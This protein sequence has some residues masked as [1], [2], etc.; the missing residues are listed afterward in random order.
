MKTFG[1]PDLFE[2]SAHSIYQYFAKQSTNGQDV[3]LSTCLVSQDVVKMRSLETALEEHLSSGFYCAVQN[4]KASQSL[5]FSKS[6]DK[7]V[8]HLSTRYNC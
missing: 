3:Y 4:V 7:Y 2:P 5:P 1:I 8:L 6:Y